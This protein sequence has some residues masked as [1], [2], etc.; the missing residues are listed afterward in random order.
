VREGK[1]APRG[2]VAVAI[3]LAGLAGAP[4]AQAAGRR[5]VPA[6]GPQV[7]RNA[8]DHGAQARSARQTLRVYLAPRG[9]EDALKAAVAAVSEP[10]SAS[11]GHYLTPQ[12]F[13]AQWDPTPATVAS[14]TSWLKSQGLKVTG[15]DAHNRFLTVKGDAAAAEAAFAT[16]LHRFTKGGE[17]F[18]APTQTATVPDDVAGA[19][20][21]VDGLST[22]TSTMAP[23]AKHFPP[24]AAFVNARPCSAT[25]GQVK[26][27]YQ[28]D[29]KTPLP[30]FDGKTL[31][32]APCGYTPAQFRGAYEG[33]KAARFNGTGQ[34]VAIV[35]AYAA[36]TIEQDADTYATR[37][38]DAAFAPG[39]L[40]QSN[41]A[42]FT[43]ANA[44]GPSGW[45]GEETLD[46]EAVHGMA[47][48][49]NVHYYGAASC[50]DQDLRDSLT[51]AVE[52]N[53]PIV[54]NSWGDVESN[55]DAA[56]IV[57]FEQI[58][59][60]GALQGITFLFSSGD[61]GDEQAASGILQADY[62]ASDPYITAVGGTTTAIYS[63]GTQQS[64]GWGTNKWALSPDGQSWDPLGFLYGSG[65]GFSSLFNR[66]DWQKTVPDS[67]PA[68]RAVPDLA[69]DAD[70]TTGMLV[71]ET[72]T[73]PSGVAYGE[74]RIGGTSLASPL[75]AGFLAL[76]TQAAGTR[77]G[78][79]NPKLYK[80]AQSRPN[81]IADVAGNP[82]GDEGNVRPDYANS[83]DAS[84]GILYSVR[85]FNQDS[86]LTV[87]PGWD[88][89]TG[90]GVPTPQFISRFNAG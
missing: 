46:V 55:E 26:A 80:V 16:A 84:Q 29:F 85:T 87:T 60:Q 54:T 28:A 56:G 77:Q 24:P 10:G 3:A 51:Q 67:A 73:F 86:S 64:T 52:D 37:H 42:K 78:F 72:Q 32:Y 25:Y 31:P 57:A 39:Q 34:D 79:I 7:T 6:A 11:Y 22:R 5:A 65:G 2:R 14:V 15:A 19:I 13:H 74:Y 17:T 90:N 53:V 47:P 76:T 69:L 66:P 30:K 41:A 35:D 58:F 49:A 4:A 89:V 61:D 1:R 21:G 18:Q 68:G 38:G 40:S 45:F 81:L 75:F 62:P 70:P 44:C 27:S 20:L 9:G 83:L 63:D 48:A 33:D 23:K 50:F 71:G 59:Q 36:D 8:T 88:D 82:I 12:Q 43:H